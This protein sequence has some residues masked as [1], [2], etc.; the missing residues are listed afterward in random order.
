MPAHQFRCI[1]VLLL[2][3]D[4]GPGG[5]SIGHADETEGLAGPDHELLRQPRKVQ[6]ALAGRRQVIECEIAIGHGIE[7]VGCRLCETQRLRGHLPVDRESGARQRGAAQRTLVQT[8]SR[9]LEPTDVSGC[10]FVIGHQMVAQR[11][12]LR[13]LQVGE[14]W[15]DRSGMFIGASRQ[16]TLQRLQPG[17][18]LVHGIARP[19]TEIGCH[20][21]V[22]ASGRVQPTGHRPDQFGQ[23][24]LGG[25]VDVF[26]VPVFGH[27]IALVFTGDLL[28]AVDNRLRIGV[29]HDIAGSQHGDMRLA[30]SYVVT[31]QSLVE[32][33]RRIDLAHYGRGALGKPPA[34]HCIGGCIL[35]QVAPVPIWFRRHGGFCSQRVR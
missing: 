35:G 17:D 3:H 26:Q 24:R 18:R 32:R 1:R 4:G 33:D 19:Q 9:I 15:H 10:H 29:C 11:Y 14:A 31:P 6:R 21:I 34:P 20:L 5:K 13:R 23:P 8:L 2:R 12:G 27:A 22:A 30:C 7:T 16:R 28:Q 25:H